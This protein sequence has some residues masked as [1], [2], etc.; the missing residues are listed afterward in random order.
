MIERRNRQFSTPLEAAVARNAHEHQAGSK[1]RG[2]P[3]LRQAGSP[4]DPTSQPRRHGR[5]L[6]PLSNDRE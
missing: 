4:D 3:A 5:T 6:S 1:P 2:A